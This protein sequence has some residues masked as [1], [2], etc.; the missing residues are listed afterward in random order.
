MV[1]FA[2]LFAAM[3]SKLIGPSENPIAKA[4]PFA[5][6]CLLDEFFLVLFCFSF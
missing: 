6:I 2:Y 5:T 1:V 3:F 4:L